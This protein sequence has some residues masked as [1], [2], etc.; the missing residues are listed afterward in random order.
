M[1]RKKW[2]SE[3]KFKIVTEGIS[4]KVPLGELC[5]RHGI[6]QGLY[7]KWRDQFFKDGKKIFEGGGANAGKQRLEAE[8]MRLKALIGELTLELKKTEF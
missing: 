1:D 2:S 4:N 5:S 3:D 7:Y 8:N 6:S